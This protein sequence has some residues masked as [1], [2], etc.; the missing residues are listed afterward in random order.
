MPGRRR[1]PW[2]WIIAAGV[3]A[4]LVAG[5]ALAGGFEPGRAR[6]TRVAPGEVFSSGPIELTIDQAVAVRPESPGD[7]WSVLVTGH[8]RTTGD[9]TVVL[10]PAGVHARNPVNGVIASTGFTIE[11]HPA[12]F[13]PGVP[14]FEFTLEFGFAELDVPATTLLVRVDDLVPDDSYRGSLTDD[15]PWQPGPTGHLVEVPLTRR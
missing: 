4:A 9:R 11:G 2:A 1:P 5:V 3:L 10:P 15:Q 13:N 14:T 6:L 7:P 8:G 12:V